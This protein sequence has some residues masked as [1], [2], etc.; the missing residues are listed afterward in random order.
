MD[1]GQ[2]IDDD[3]VFSWFY[4]P[5]LWDTYI[6]KLMNLWSECEGVGFATNVDYL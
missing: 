2:L 6:T 4:R 1:L 3:G 5:I